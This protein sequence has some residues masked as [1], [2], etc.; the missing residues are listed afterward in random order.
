MERIRQLSRFFENMAVWRPFDF[1]NIPSSSRVNESDRGSD[2][3]LCISE[4]ET[5]ETHVSGKD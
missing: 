3:I 1:E 5:E 4:L 2:I